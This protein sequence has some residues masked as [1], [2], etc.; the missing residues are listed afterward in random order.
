MATERYFDKSIIEYGATVGMTVRHLRKT[1]NMAKSIFG[2]WKRYAV[3]ACTLLT[4]AA[5]LDSG[6]FAAGR[7][8]GQS[9]LGITALDVETGKEV[10]LGPGVSGYLIA[11]AT[12]VDPAAHKMYVERSD[13]HLL[14]IDTLN[15]AIADIGLLNTALNSFV[16]EPS[17][18]SLVG[19]GSNS[20]VKIDVSTCKETLIAS[21]SGTYYAAAIALDSTNNLLYLEETEGST[22]NLVVFNTDT[23]FKTQ[24][25]PL[26]NPVGS[27]AFVQENQTLVGLVSGEVLKINTQTATETI[28][29]TVPAGYYIATAFA[30]D[31]QRIYMEESTSAGTELVAYDTTSGEKTSIAVLE[32]PL[33]SFV[34]DPTPLDYNP[35]PKNEGV[36]D[37]PNGCV[38]NPINTATGNKFQTETDFVGA[39]NTG[40]SLKRYYN[41]QDTSTS[42]FGPNWRD[43]WH[44]SLSVSTDGNTVTVTRE[45]GRVDTFKKNTSG[46]AVSIPDANIYVGN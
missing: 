5:L 44:R 42:P 35:D 19:L 45:D 4:A 39:S 1:K 11:F 15:G 23:G 6:A 18:K 37:C 26:P 16:F 29:K 32:N 46:A 3:A 12:A 13:N 30:S 27:F 31:A 7:L 10:L 25:G 43:T 17:D 20:L 36:P 22:T 8:V 2:D 21:D 38:S 33:G 24:I 28:L 9:Q 41:N 34:F 14:S 40:L